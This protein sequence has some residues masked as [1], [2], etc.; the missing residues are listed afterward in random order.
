MFLFTLHLILGICLG[1][2]FKN[3]AI[4]VFIAIAI[5]YILKFQK[6]KLV[7]ICFIISVLIYIHVLDAETKYEK[8]FPQDFKI[9]GVCE[10]IS[11]A[12]EK[13]YTNKY[14]VK[15]NKK[16]LIAYIDKEICLEY[17][18]VIFCDGEFKKASSSRNLKGFNYERYLRQSKIYGIVNVEDVKVLSK[19]RGIFYSF[20]K[21]KNNLKNRINES[22]EEKKAGF[23]T[24]ILL[25]DKEEID[26]D[27][28]DDFKNSN[29]SHILAISGMHVVYIMTMMEF[30]TSK[31][32]K[33]KKLQNYILI[34]FLVFFMVFTG[35]SAS[36]M[37][38]CIMMIIG[39]I[40]KNLYRK[41]DFF[42]T[43][44]LTL[45]IILIFNYYNIENI[46]MWLSFLGAFALGRIDNSKNFLISN[47][48]SSF[49]VQMMIFPIILYSYNTIS[50]TF[51]ISN[52][53]VSFLIAPI[54]ILGYVSLF[55]GKYFKILI[56]IENLLIEILFKIAEFVGN[57]K[58][59]KIYFITPHIIFFIVYY[60]LILVYKFAKNK[61][62]IKKCFILL[63]II[64]I[65]FSKFNFQQAFKM[66][67]LDVGQG[68]CS[69]IVSKSGKRIL[70]DGGNDIGYDYGEN[71][72]LP[73]LL[74]N[75]IG[76]LDYVIVSH[77][78]SDHCGGLFYILE[79]IKVRNVI[80]GKQFENNENLKRFIEIVEKRKINLII[81]KSGS[82]V[83]IEK[84]LYLD[85]LW[86]EIHKK[87][88]NNSINNNALVFKL[89]YNNFSV[90]FTGDIEKEAEDILISQYKKTL[91]STILKVP[92]HGSSTSSTENFLREVDSKIA[93]IGVGEDNNF[94]HPSEDVIQ[95]MKKLRD[96]D[97]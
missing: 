67:F 44:C 88:S 19:N 77:F 1:L 93:L 53:F 15:Y 17:G 91:K 75:G 42:T 8:L 65:I 40:A 71:V 63:I 72:V 43:L 25:G 11:F 85:I 89:N 74:K 37:R 64:C 78:D 70:V 76:Y 96:T 58:F 23:L 83:Y 13:E 69:L 36:C 33:F 46:G 4:F 56:L 34:I 9:N 32:I 57:F 18:D 97:F 22:F 84:N 24:G 29:L 26:E 52:F 20:F 48:K 45:N 62:F 31:F 28:K 90:L 41:N 50:F 35:S 21:L 55:L 95:R 51:F 5:I 80:I 39:L 14:I 61:E 86:P 2:Y 94:G 10:V 66:Y 47:L 6:Y 12:E 54:L 7:Y 59:S 27:I 87:I 92:H 73:Y 60:A 3:I 49:A 79:N 16:K 30:L 81:A 68:D 38:A 82:R